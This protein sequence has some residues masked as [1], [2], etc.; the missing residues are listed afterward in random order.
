M[1]GQVSGLC[2][3]PSWRWGVVLAL[4]AACG[5]DPT[6]TPPP[7]PPPPPP[8]P[9][10]PASLL[11]AGGNN[12]ATA[13]STLV[14][15]APTVRVLDADGKGIG[16]VPLTLTVLSGQGSL[17]SETVTTDAEGIA[18]AEGWR[19]GPMP[20]ENRLQA[21]VANLPP[22]QITAN[23]RY[24][25][26]TTPVSGMVTLPGG[27][28]LQAAALRVQT[29]IAD[30]PVAV[31]GAFTA[32]ALPGGAQ[33]AVAHA[34]NGD[35]VMMGWFD[36]A[37]RTLNARTTAE[38][39]SY[40][41]LGAYQ[42]PESERRDSIR[43]WLAQA[44]LDPLV[45]AISA[46]LSGPGAQATLAT[47]TIA[48]AR[49]GVLEGFRADA[50]RPRGIII[51]PAGVEQSGI[52][53]D[54]VGLNAVTI[55]NHRRRRVRAFVDR[56]SYVARGL[57]SSQASPSAG[58]PITIPAVGAATSVI[59]TGVDILFG[60]LAW[61]PV[62]SA[63]QSV[64]LAPADAVATRYRVTVVGAGQPNPAVPLTTLQRAEQRQAALETLILDAVLPLLD[65]LLQADNALQS[66]GT[67]TD[68][69]SFVSK[70]I[71]LLPTAAIEAAIAGNVQAALQETWK[72]LIDSGPAQDLLL[73]AYFTLI[74][75]QGIPKEAILGKAKAWGKALGIVE[76]IATMGD[77][78]VVVQ[79]TTTAQDAV[80]WDVNVGEAEVRLDPPVAVIANTELQVL[81]A[82]VLEA[83]DGG[84]APV[85]RYRW[86]TTGTVG[87]I[88]AQFAGCA[89]SIPASSRDVVSYS[90]DV[91]KEGTDEVRVVV[92][93]VENG[94][95]HVIGEATSQIT[96]FA[97][98]V[99]IA[100]QQVSI[101]YDEQVTLT[102]T[103]DPRL[104]DGGVLSYRWSTA[105]ALGSFLFGETQA[106]TQLP[107]V[108]YTA[109]RQ[110]EGTETVTVTVLS[111]TNGV[112]RDLGS[113]TAT[114][115]VEHQ[116]PTVVMGSWATEG[117]TGL[118]PGRS[119][120]TAY[121]SFPLEPGA[122]SYSVH[123]YGFVDT[124]HWGTEINVPV[125]PPTDTY[126]PCT[127]AT[128]WGRSGTIGNEYRFLLSGFAG[129]DSS[130]GNAISSFTSRFSGMIVEVT[131][132]Y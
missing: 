80:Q 6:G 81:H 1:G 3:V 53:V 72:T 49:R 123:A 96:T 54:Q 27:A 59:G 122:R 5:G 118:D 88:C 29:G 100:P 107:T 17:D 26:P 23:G 130:I 90:P 97:P 50:S 129:P 48:T 57:G 63:P 19:L 95:E 126:L 113:A 18:K 35:A 115:L 128:G 131:V 108:I 78:Y 83:T 125:V 84:P 22:V 52:V 127:L 85:F 77:L 74:A 124:A 73:N 24:L 106:V 30:V 36:A 20:S 42:V 13:P 121:L 10:Q 87:Q 28:S 46:M 114:I 104:L 51:D 9:T 91:H 111:T 102:A 55:T 58:Q 112:T 65:Q 41:D 21:S 66:R 60:N 75:G 11:I 47:P 132:Q 7:Q 109:H 12:Q 68:V 99:Q 86:S 25:V 39:L 43:A 15:V 94:T 56:V 71:D 110:I 14:P 119:C 45:A 64:P 92:Y 101:D 76:A 116:R 31:N 70:F 16:G 38:V 79:H 44:D 34:P 8:P 103:A 32:S 120:V 93:Y 4:A 117:P 33:L 61:A 69:S 89:T 98:K 67:G 37:H 105:G 82:V 40:F 62:V 2:R